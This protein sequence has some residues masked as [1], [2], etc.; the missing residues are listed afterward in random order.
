MRMVILKK[1]MPSES[2]EP[3][4]FWGIEINIGIIIVS[5]PDYFFI[6][7]KCR[8][9]VLIIWIWH[10][11]TITNFCVLCKFPCRIF[12]HFVV[13]WERKSPF[14]EK[15]FTICSYLSPFRLPHLSFGSSWIESGVR[16]KF[17]VNFSCYDAV[18]E[19]LS[20]NFSHVVKNKRLPGI[21]QKAAFDLGIPALYHLHLP[22]PSVG[23]HLFFRTSN[24]SSG[25]WP[26]K[27]NTSA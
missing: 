7:K 13:K 19:I 20:V 17:F 24:S 2:A 25:S 3:R 27:G 14:F 4:A 16:C 9:E 18:I 10:A 26:V 1:N 6:S 23:G 5:H 22:C 21:I 11:F 12:G 15:V 8:N